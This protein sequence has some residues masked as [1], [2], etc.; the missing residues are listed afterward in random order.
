MSKAAEVHMKNTASPSQEE[1][2]EDVLELKAELG[3]LGGV[4]RS[5]EPNE[6]IGGNKF[7]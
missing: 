1:P 7:M 5:V 3:A 2:A 4:G 6:L